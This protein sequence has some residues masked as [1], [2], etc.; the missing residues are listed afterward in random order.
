MKVCALA[1]GSKGNSTYVSSSTTKLLIDL[2]T[3]SL[4]VEKKLREI[5][6]EP[7]EITGI[8]ISHTHSDHVNGLRV[9]VKKYNT[10]LFLT[11]KMLEDIN[12]IFHVDN[13][14]LIDEEFTIG[15]IKISTIKTSH[16]ASD[17]NGYILNNDD[18]SVVYITDT[19]YINQK[20]HKKLYNK[21]VYVFESNYDV[22]KLM[23]SK[24]P[25]YLKQRIISDKGHLSNHD[26]AYYLSKFI[27]KDTKA[28]ILAH[29]SHENND[30]DIALKTLKDKLE[31]ENISFNNIMISTQ[32]QRTDLI[33]V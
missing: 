24:Y 33:E 12:K 28:V 29:L 5:N 6:V 30:P 7:K 11:K 8:L 10:T 23:N 18:S 3:T 19:G 31:E 9:F 22:E 2:G 25:Y 14:V 15:D 4:H 17:S 21:N 20:H 13:Y 26:S 16:D 27:G 1:S 32:E